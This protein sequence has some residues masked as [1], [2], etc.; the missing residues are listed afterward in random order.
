MNLP[1]IVSEEEWRA[2]RAEL[3]AEEKNATR[4]LDALAARRRRLP[5]V[6]VSK[7]YRL[8]GPEG[9]VGLLDL[10]EGR[11]Q[12][13]VYSFMLPP[14]APRPCEGC[15]ML[16]DGMGHPAHLRARDTN[17]VLVSRAPL[18]EIEAVRRRMGWTLPWYSAKDSEFNVDV[19]A[20]S[21]RGEGFALNVFLRDGDRVFRTYYT[22]DRGVDR[23]N[24]NFNYLDLTPFG[25]QETWE[26]SPQGWP[27]TPPYEYW[28]LHDEYA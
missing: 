27:Q 15:S 6:E 8:E 16:V 12:L 28:R 24:A 3:L 2:A 10:F 7:Q 5:M 9:P 23:L 18:A 17:L 21:E 13:I 19:D 25:R 4:M 1:A 11:R 20:M 14:G 22:S 26:D